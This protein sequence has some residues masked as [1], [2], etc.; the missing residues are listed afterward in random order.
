MTNEPASQTRLGAAKEA[1]G[2]SYQAEFLDSHPLFLR[3]VAWLGAYPHLNIRKAPT[4]MQTRTA[5]I[6][7]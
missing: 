5:D 6:G 1:T 4:P 7:K 2:L 3:P